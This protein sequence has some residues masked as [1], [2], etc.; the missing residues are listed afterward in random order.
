MRK[1]DW[2]YFKLS[3]ERKKEQEGGWKGR[4]EER[5]EKERRG[6]KKE[7]KRERERERV[8]RNEEGVK[9]KEVQEGSDQ[10]DFGNIVIYSQSLEK[11]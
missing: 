1:F 8:R 5:Q 3:Q 7:R 2:F 4:N 6:R 10:R 11:H 9:R